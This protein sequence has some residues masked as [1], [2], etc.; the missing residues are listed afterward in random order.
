MQ[1]GATGHADSAVRT[2]WNV[3][4]SEGCAA[5]DQAINIGRV[6]VLVAEAMNRVETL[7]VGKDDDDIRFAHLQILTGVVF[8]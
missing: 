8:R 7:V 5:P 2:A 1:H 3:S 6:N 4:L